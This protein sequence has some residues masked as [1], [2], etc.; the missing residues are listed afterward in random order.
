MKMLDDAAKLAAETKQE[1]K[2]FL[3]G[4]IA[5]RQDGVLVKSTNAK[6]RTPEASGHAEARS[7]RKAGFGATLWVARVLRDGSWAMAKPCKHC[8]T[9]IRNK[10]VKKV[11]YTTGPNS[12]E[13][14]DP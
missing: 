11:Y 5:E 14:W 1:G 6:V 9:L 10:G 13:S 4:C 3:L 7:L 12:W 2:Q 8:E